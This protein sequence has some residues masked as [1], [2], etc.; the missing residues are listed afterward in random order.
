MKDEKHACSWCG[1]DVKPEDRDAETLRFEGA[2]WY[3][4]ACKEK[5]NR[6]QTQLD[7]GGVA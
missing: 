3:H 5:S 2:A 7:F 4:A 6:Q 1:R